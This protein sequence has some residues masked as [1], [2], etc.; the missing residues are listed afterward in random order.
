[1]LIVYADYRHLA[2]ILVSGKLNNKQKSDCDHLWWDDVT[3]SVALFQVR[4]IICDVRRGVS[5]LA[6]HQ[7]DVLHELSTLS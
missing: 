6:G 5:N 4:L 3:Q 1:M 7:Q 2:G